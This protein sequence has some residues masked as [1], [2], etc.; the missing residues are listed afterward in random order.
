MLLD[1]TVVGCQAIHTSEFPVLHEV[2]T[3]SYLARQVQGGGVGTR[4]RALVLELSFGDLGG[5]VGDEWVRRGNQP[6]CHV[7]ARLGYQA[8]GIEFFGGLG[9]G[10]A[11][12]SQRLRPSLLTLA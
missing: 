9:A 1:G 6:S 12:K 11:V 7:S 4:M 3:G 5:K 8:D 2:H 10:E